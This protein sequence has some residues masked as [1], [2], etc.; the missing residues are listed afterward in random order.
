MYLINFNVYFP[1]RYF[2]KKKDD[3][4]TLTSK[5]QNTSLKMEEKKE[6]EPQKLIKSKT[7]FQ[8][9]GISSLACKKYPNLL[10]FL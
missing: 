8:T 2:Q 5:S 3:F 6:E 1:S 7:I 10:F 4:Q 9:S